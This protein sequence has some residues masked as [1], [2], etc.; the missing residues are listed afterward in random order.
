MKQVII[1]WTF[2][3]LMLLSGIILPSIFIVEVS[4]P[5][6]E[7]TNPTE[8]ISPTEETDLIDEKEWFVTDTKPTTVPPQTEPET[9][10]T[11]DPEL[12]KWEERYVEYPVATTVWKHLTENMGYNDYVAA[13]VI[14]NMMA[15]C[16]GQ[17][18]NLQWQIYN[19]TG[20]YGLCQWS[21]G[22][23]EVQGADLQGQLDFMSKSFPEQID[24][25]G[26]ICYKK[27]FT[28]EDF[29]VLEDA[30]EAAYA[31]C[32]IYERPGPG[33]HQQRRENAIKAY[34]YF[35]T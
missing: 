25:W 7:T 4:E 21:T 33:T 31:F 14:G 8:T 13:G 26:S 30:A 35:T 16:G 24:H 2:V 29:M 22:F 3:C 1:L 34:E 18:L 9:E 20:H 12:Q 19:A 6:I 28:H 32:I 17:T 27:G 10:P 5:I 15:E 23:T 11:E